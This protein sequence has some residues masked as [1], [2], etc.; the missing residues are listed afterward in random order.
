LAAA[1]G[2]IDRVCPVVLLYHYPDE[3]ALAAAQ[4]V[5]LYLAGHTHGGQVRIP[6]YGAVI[7]LTRTGKRFEWGPY[8]MGDTRMYVNRG[9]GMEGGTAPRVRFLARPEVTVFDLVST[10]PAG[11]GRNDGVESGGR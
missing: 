8:A 9:I 7:T 11:A 6:W 2:P 1:R 4:G 3:I 10:A 5:D